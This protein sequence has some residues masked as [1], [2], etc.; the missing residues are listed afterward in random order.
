MKIAIVETIEAN[1]QKV[2]VTLKMWNDKVKQLNMN[3]MTVKQNLV[4]TKTLEYQ[5]AYNTQLKE[6]YSKIEEIL[7]FVEKG[8]K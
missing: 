2:E 8:Y 6:A 1:I 4:I 7:R 5:N 3:P